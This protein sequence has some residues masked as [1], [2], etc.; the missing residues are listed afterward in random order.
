[1]TGTALA[2][3]RLISSCCSSIGLRE[4]HRIDPEKLNAYRLEVASGE[5]IPTVPAT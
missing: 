1:M 4:R 2:A 5:A 3:C